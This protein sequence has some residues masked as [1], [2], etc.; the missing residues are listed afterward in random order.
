MYYIVMEMFIKLSIQLYLYIKAI[1]YVKY[2]WNK[3]SSLVVREM[4]VVS[5]M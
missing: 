4:L 3:L 2:N 5:C 1:N